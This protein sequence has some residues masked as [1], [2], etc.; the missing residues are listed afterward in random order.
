MTAR[1]VILMLACVL[2]VATS[3][4][5]S[6]GLAAAGG[7]IGV[8]VVLGIVGLR[9]TTFETTEGQRY[10]VPNG[11]IG[12]AVSAL[13]LG[14]LAARLFTMPE[15]MAAARAGGPAVDAMQRSPLTLALFCLLA[16]YY[17]SYY[18]GVL[19]RSK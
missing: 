19:W 14:R 16:G 17:A 10:Y 12:I 3:S 5:T 18:A 4:P 15:R 13:F 1:I 8:G 7:G 9:L 6:V 11:W 2:I